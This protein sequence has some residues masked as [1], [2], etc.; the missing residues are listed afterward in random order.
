M[1]ERTADLALRDPHVVL[2]LRHMLFG[3]RLL[4]KRPGQHELGFKHRT[5]GI[6]ETVEGRGHPFVHRVLH[7][8][9]NILDD[10]TGVALVPA[11]IE[12]FGHRAELNDQIFG[13]VFGLDL[14][15]F[16]PP[17]ANEQAFVVTHD[18][19]GVRTADKRA[20]ICV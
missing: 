15:S 12:F 8:S 10:V 13:E 9:L 4:R 16:F 1:M 17:K 7:L 3:C 11:P 5:T 20:A 18:D 19:P 2:Q 6:D 14:A